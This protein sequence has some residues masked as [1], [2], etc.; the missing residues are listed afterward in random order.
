MNIG[1]VVWS[2]VL[3]PIP[4]LIFHVIWGMKIFRENESTASALSYHNMRNDPYL[5]PSKND[6]MSRL[7]QR[8]QLLD[9]ESFEKTFQLLLFC[10]S[11][12]FGSYFTLLRLVAQI[13]I[14]PHLLGYYTLIYAAVVSS[15]NT[16]IVYLV[17]LE[18]DRFV[19][20]VIDNWP[21]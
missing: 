5:D 9:D 4:N 10:N 21:N 20:D 8:S 6:S 3:S 7:Y 1:Y 17:K 16:V 15:L 13:V 19:S 14:S 11:A 2:L 12:F 18:H